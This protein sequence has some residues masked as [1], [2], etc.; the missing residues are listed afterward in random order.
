[1]AFNY[2]YNQLDTSS[3][4]FQSAYVLDNLK[5]KLSLIELRKLVKKHLLIGE[6]QCKIVKD[7]I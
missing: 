4:G 6:Q 5:E 3:I 1:M 2:S 7:H